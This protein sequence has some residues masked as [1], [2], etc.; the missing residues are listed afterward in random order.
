MENGLGKIPDPSLK[1]IMV[2]V[3][4]D[5]VEKGVWR[6]SSNLVEEVQSLL[7][8]KHLQRSQAQCLTKLV[9]SCAD[10][11]DACGKH[12]W[13]DT[14]DGVVSARNSLVIRC[15]EQSLVGKLPQLAGR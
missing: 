5:R 4:Q 3:K 9:R 2:I 10:E 1:S 7:P 6:G 11:V 15:R 12:T 8:P 13:A 14:W